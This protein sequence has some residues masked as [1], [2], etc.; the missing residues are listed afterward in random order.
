M[1]LDRRAAASTDKAAELLD[2]LAALDTEQRRKLAKE[3]RKVVGSL[4]DVPDAEPAI[5]T[6]GLLA[7]W[8][9]PS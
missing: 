6:L 9:D 1:P 7:H 2:Q 8:L 5:H 4:G 3:L